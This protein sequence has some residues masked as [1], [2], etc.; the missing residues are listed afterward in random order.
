MLALQGCGGGGGGG[1][2]PSPP[3]SPPTPSPPKPGPS[4]L[5]WCEDLPTYYK[6]T[7][8]TNGTKSAAG[9]CMPSTTPGAYYTKPGEKDT[10]GKSDRPWGCFAPNLDK[11]LWTD[12]E[13]RKQG[14]EGACLN[15]DYGS[16]ATPESVDVCSK[17]LS[18]HPAVCA[19]GPIMYWGACW[20]SHSENWK[21]LP[22]GDPTIPG[23]AKGDCTAAVL[24]EPASSVPTKYF[25][26]GV[27]RFAP[28]TSPLYKC[29]TVSNYNAESAAT[30]GQKVDVTNNKACFSLESGTQWEC[31]P[32]KTAFPTPCDWTMQPSSNS[33]Y[34]GACVFPGNK[35]YEKAIDAHNLTK[36]VNHE[37]IV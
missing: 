2:T 19:P 8:D 23:L 29:D 37:V 14:F 22:I 4:G 13:A 15:K 11:D 10:D 31:L 24:L 12:D 26:D 30:C 1:G 18:H 32:E 20:S 5:Y 35:Q 36:T 25:Y 3:P 7:Y 6:V 27:C 21:C 9:Q 16:S 28:D 34:E 17:H 33:F